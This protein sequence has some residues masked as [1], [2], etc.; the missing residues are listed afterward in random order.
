MEHD[1]DAVGVAGRRLVDGVVDQLPQ[2]GGR[3]RPRRCRRCTCRVACGRPRALR[4]SGWRRRRSAGACRSAA[5]PGSGH[6]LHHLALPTASTAPGGAGRR[7]RRAGWVRPAAA[8]GWGSAPGRDRR[9]WPTTHHSR[10]TGATDRQ[11][12]RAVL[13]RRSRVEAH[14]AGGRGPG[15]ARRR[16]A[17]TFSPSP[18][19]TVTHHALLGR[20]AGGDQPRRRAAASCRPRPGRPVPGGGCRPT[21]VRSAWA[22]LATITHVAVLG[23]PEGGHQRDPPSSRAMSAAPSRSDGQLVGRRAAWPRRRR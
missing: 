21:A 16:S 5:L 9:R 2:R 15:G 12:E 8:W 18:S 3:G 6:G 22:S 11:A 7:R 14:A 4:A 19:L 17:V 23:R 13:G 20:R 1:L 10:A